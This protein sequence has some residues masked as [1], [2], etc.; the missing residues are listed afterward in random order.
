MIITSELN[1]RATYLGFASLTLVLLGPSSADADD[2]VSFLPPLGN[3]EQADHA[4]SREVSDE[5]VFSGDAPI[6][7]TTSVQIA[8][9]LEKQ[10][11]EEAKEAS[12]T[13]SVIWDSIRQSEG[14]GLSDT[15]LTERYK[16]NYLE[17]AHF[18][19]KLLERSR[20]YI[21]HLVNALD[22][23]YLPVELA[24]LPAVESGFLPHGV[25]VDNAVGLWQIVPITAK[26]I[27]ITRTRWFDG[28]ADIITS[29]TAA[30]DYLSY[31]NAEFDGDWELTLAAYNAGPGRVRRAIKRNASAGKGTS[32]IDLDLPQETKNYLPKFAALVQLVKDPQHTELELPLVNADDA[33]EVVDIGKR[34]SLDKL[35][36]LT[37]V[38][39]A[40]LKNL[41]AGLTLGV[42]PPKGPHSVYL[43]RDRVSEIQTAVASA[44]PEQLF[45]IPKNHTVVAGDTLGGI[46]L[47]YSMSMQALQTLNRLE[48]DRIRIGQKLSVVDSRFVDQPKLVQYKVASGDTLSDIAA[49]FS[50]N[51]SEI[52][53]AGGKPLD[54]DVIRPGDTLQIRV[55]SANGS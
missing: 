22:E 34:V 53:S 6:L 5:H 19:N 39:E 54:S 33:F 36:A 44:K 2:R 29:T 46:A 30:I 45:Q 17:Q 35:A 50:V 3:T 9:E 24:L 12:A 41:N 20:P 14:L 52:V 1:W 26:E 55:L 13:G 8:I 43:P 38:P 51:V 10:A 7:P 18:T 47:Q 25:S 28:R 48:S 40:I 15:D 49:Q 4:L 16:K 23:R 27:G 21:A 42:T 11:I 31:L 37:T 32:F